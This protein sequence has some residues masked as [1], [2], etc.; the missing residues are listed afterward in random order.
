MLNK[1]K[2]I[3]K[4]DELVAL[5]RR[6]AGSGGI[7]TIYGTEDS[8]E[9][10]SATETFIVSLY[11]KD[12]PNHKQFLEVMRTFY[13]SD[14]KEAV[15]ILI[16]IKKHVEQGWMD[17]IKNHLSAE[18]FNDYLDM[19]NY[20]NQEGFYIAAA[21]IAGTTLEERVR[22]LCVLHGVSV[23]T[24]DA[25][26]GDMKPIKADTLN[27]NVASHYADSRNDARL[28]VKNYGL[29]NEAAHGKWNDDSAAKK[30]IRI[31]QVNVMI[32]EVG[33]FVRNNPI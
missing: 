8:R 19:A 5:G 23:E 6:V 20:L 11:G 33:F 29:R 9:F 22:Q 4:I 17:N 31:D 3:D 10:R 30:S 13:A 28:F 26:T 15:G 16:G 24:S 2:Y 18:I 27:I 12:S 21:V 1:Q 25:R 14:Y 32:Q 7:D